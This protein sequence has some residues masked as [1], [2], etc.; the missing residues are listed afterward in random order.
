MTKGWGNHQYHLKAAFVPT[1]KQHCTACYKLELSKGTMGAGS[2][3]FL[4]MLA[5][6]ALLKHEAFLRGARLPGSP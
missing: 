1:I 5:A 6:A 4:N 2:W 3:G